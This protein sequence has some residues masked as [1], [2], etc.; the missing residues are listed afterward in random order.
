MDQELPPPPY[1]LHD[2][3]PSSPTTTPNTAPCDNPHVSG[4]AYFEMRPPTRP[5]PA[6]TLP[7]HIAVL[8]DAT[9][10]HLPMPEPNRIL[11]DRDV[12]SHDWITF[13]NHLLPDLP[14]H[15]T[16]KSNACQGKSVDTKGG[17]GRV[18]PEQEALASSVTESERQRKVKAVV[19]E[20]NQGFFLPRGIQIVARVE[21]TPR[22]DRLSHPAS[23]ELVVDGK[24]RRKRNQ[25]KEPGLALYHAI[26]KQDL[27]TCEALLNA[28]ADPNAR[29]SWKTP[30]VVEAVNRGNLKILNMLLDYELDI[31]AN[32]PG[33]G[34]ALYNAVAKGKADTVKALLRY[35]AD[36]NKRPTGEQPL[37]YKAA[38]KQYDEI[39]AL[40]LQY[41]INIDDA[42]V[43]EKTAL[44]M[45]ANKGNLELVEKLLAAG[46][47]PDL[48]PCGSE[49][50]LFDSAKKSHF[51]ICQSLLVNGAD[52]D[53]K[54]MGGNTALWHLVGDK[55]ERLVRLLLDHGADINAKAWGGES[56][57]ERAVRKGRTDMVQLLLQ[58]A[59]RT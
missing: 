21:V 44:H 5:S 26:K 8:P 14:Y 25:N 45:V 11:V 50:A 53:A 42:S 55:D 19:E 33:E 32:A 10:T 43:G 56:V 51:E 9:A 20:W 7:C 13:V 36:P 16:A 59:Q 1:S 27:S 48:R 35:G 4:A 41:N 54:T 28:G 49:T 39:V 34:A 15:P 23:S 24:S 18:E 3:S 31:N 47:K 46:A 37:L 17:F 57:I 52:V 29:Q 40:L 58:Y 22:S 2:P 12:D 6:G 38:S 30:A